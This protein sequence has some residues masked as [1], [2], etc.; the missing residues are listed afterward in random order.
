MGALF[1]LLVAAV[2]VMAAAAEIRSSVTVGDL[3]ENKKT[4]LGLYLSPADAA[5][6]L[7]VDPSI[8]FL[9]VRDPIEI[10]FVG[11]PVPIDA[12][13]PWLIVRLEF[14]EN[15]GAYKTGPN[16]NFVADIDAVVARERSGKA[17]PIFVM[18]RSGD[19]SAAAVNALASVGYTNVWTL[20]EGFEGDKDDEGERS[21]N[22]WRNAG[23]PWTYKLTAGE[24][25]EP[26][27]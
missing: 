2:P 22:G 10:T 6:A 17:K 11:H 26:P 9:D 4:E 3:P 25:W 8:V 27:N 12:I 14:D 13:V 16:S 18:C 24:A 7:E 19:R 5:A 1:G 23:L 15:S 20:V 21:L